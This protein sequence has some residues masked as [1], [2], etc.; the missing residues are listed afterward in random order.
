MH[1]KKRIQM[2]VSGYGGT[3]MKQNFKYIDLGQ[4]SRLEHFQYFR[5]MAYPYMGVTCDVD[6]TDF[7]CKIK[8]QK[9]PFFLSFLWCVTRAANSVPELRQRMKGEKIAEYEY[10]RTSHTVARDDGT[11]S[12]CQLDGRLP[13]AEYLSF[14]KEAQDKARTCGSIEE[15]EE[16]AESFLFISTLPWLN[17]ASLVQP[18]PSPADSNPR[19]TWGKYA[20]KEHRIMLPVSVLCH[21][22]LVDGRHLAA[23][24][25][26]LDRQISFF[27]N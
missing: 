19:I 6:I 8:T 12:Y 17:Y 5:Q 4:Y 25:T 10:C 26:E 14:A 1:R 3:E 23:F 20:E 2:T 11:Y 13:L 22:A 27:E 21:H 7:L 9:M 16:E 18:V 24:Y 15:E